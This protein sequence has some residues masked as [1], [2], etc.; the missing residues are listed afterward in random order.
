M[1]EVSCEAGRASETSTVADLLRDPAASHGLKDV[2]P[3]REIGDP[4]DAARNA[5]LL[6]EAPELRAD[7]A[8]SWAP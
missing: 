5:R 7:E 1:A 2:L 3:I 4:V 6:A 8:A